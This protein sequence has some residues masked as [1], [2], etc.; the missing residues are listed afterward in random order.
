M[1]RHMDV[2]AQSRE[3]W[4]PALRFYRRDT[5]LGYNEESPADRSAGP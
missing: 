4:F 2:L 3:R 5:W 1:K